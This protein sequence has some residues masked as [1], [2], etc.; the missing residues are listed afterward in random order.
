MKVAI[1]GVGAIR[2]TTA[3]RVIS[4]PAC[5]QQGADGGTQFNTCRIGDFQSV[6]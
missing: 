5:T 2:L 6:A 3:H 1:V 4:R